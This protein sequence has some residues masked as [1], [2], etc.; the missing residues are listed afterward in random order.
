MITY[1]KAKVTFNDNFKQDFEVE[2]QVGFSTSTET[3][4]L[5]LFEC[6]TPNTEIGSVLK[7]HGEII[8]MKFLGFVDK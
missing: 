5:L 2:L 8:E 1:G 4:W 7:T 3:F 6:I